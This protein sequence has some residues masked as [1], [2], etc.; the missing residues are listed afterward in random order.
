MKN[1]LIINFSK[2]SQ[3]YFEENKLENIIDL[4]N[5]WEMNNISFNLNYND[6]LSLFKSLINDIYG[7]SSVI[8]KV[9]DDFPI[10][11]L[12][13]LAEK[14]REWCWL[15]D[16]C[17]FVTLIKQN[18]KNIGSY[19]AIEIHA[20]FQLKDNLL[21]F[22][23]LFKH[24]N[25]KSDFKLYFYGKPS[26]ISY[27]KNLISISL[28]YIL[29]STLSKNSVNERQDD[30][31]IASTSKKSIVFNNFYNFFNSNGK[32]IQYLNIDEWI[33]NLKKNIYSK[34]LFNLRP[35]LLWLIE[36][37]F[38]LLV[39]KF[40]IAP[41]KHKKIKF[42]ECDLNLS[43]LDL[44]LKNFSTDSNSLITLIRY[45]WLK[46]YFSSIS[47]NKNIFF[48]D[49]L[50]IFGKGLSLSKL[51]SK[52]NKLSTYGI[53]HGHITELKTIY[54]LTYNELK[55]NYPSPD[56]IIVWGAFYARLLNEAGVS[57]AS[58][59]L[60]L[61]NPI[62][63]KKG[64]DVV[65][66]K[67]FTKPK[68]ILWC[69]TNYSSFLNEVNIIKSSKTIS[70]FEVI[71]RKHPTNPSCSFF[72][73]KIIKDFELS[74]FK[75]S[76]N[77]SS[78]KRSILDSDF[79]IASWDSAVLI[80]AISNRVKFCSIASPNFKHSVKRVGLPLACSSKALD[81]YLNEIL[82]NECDIVLNYKPDDFIIHNSEKFSNYFF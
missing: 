24:C 58:K 8:N 65:K 17:H 56:N 20:P 76:L 46:K 14:H 64:N 2:F 68:K 51:N 81:K 42:I 72:N 21:F 23:S 70:E 49:E 43:F 37:I 66:N 32:K 3:K 15:H 53:Q 45:N 48:E 80:D 26:L 75:I 39:N 38:S 4:S 7:Q 47:Y 44:E 60:T 82:K 59:I 33:F 29:F 19:K 5:I 27:F 6:S 63:F 16:F 52:N 77:A 40:Y 13:P 28:R 62:Y 41:I 57:S 18:K 78:I 36:T 22:K 61:G 31:F 10:I 54:S 12:T 35:S 55:S 73:D 11:H 69:L 71:I 9:I 74:D 67:I 1:K 30:I 79:V 50:Y 25:I 34:H